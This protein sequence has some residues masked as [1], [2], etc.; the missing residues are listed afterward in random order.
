M[1]IR[2]F[3]SNIGVRNFQIKQKGENNEFVFCVGIL[4][5]QSG[6]YRTSFFLKQ[7]GDKEYLQEL[8]FQLIQ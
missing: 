8:R 3:F 1:V 2:D 7:K 4:E 5:T 6:N